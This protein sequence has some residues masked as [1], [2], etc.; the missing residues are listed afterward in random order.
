MNSKIEARIEAVRLA[1]NV[2]G[3][4]PDNV[5]STSEAICYFILGDAELPDTFNTNA[6]MMGL[7]SKYF[8]K[9]SYPD[10]DETIA[11]LKEETGIKDVEPEKVKENEKADT[12]TA[13]KAWAAE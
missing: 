6:E 3:V 10:V 11:K 1:I 8:P 5:V 12:E 7:M 13:E 9:P 4:T 2:E